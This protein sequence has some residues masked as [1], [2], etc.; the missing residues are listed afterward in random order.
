MAEPIATFSAVKFIW[1][2]SK[3]IRTWLWSK[4]PF[5]ADARKKE[6]AE[7]HLADLLEDSNKLA[8]TLDPEQADAA[9]DK[10]VAQFRV[11]LLQEKIPEAEA[12]V[13]A[14]RGAMFVKLLVTG[15][16]GE[17]AILR[18]RFGQTEIVVQQ[19]ERSLERLDKD[20][21][22][23]EAFIRLEARCHS[24]HTVLI[25]SLILT[26]VAILISLVSLVVSLRGLH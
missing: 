1:T 26:A 20:A 8:R 17:S 25:A 14:E 15:P 22:S 18:E 4:L 12:D 11:A 24:M 21:I 6:A 23:K 5:A 9:I 13:L 7:N 16:M 10:R 3:P 19:M 2:E